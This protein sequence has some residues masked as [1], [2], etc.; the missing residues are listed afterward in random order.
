[1]DN[2][3]E[4]SSDSSGTWERISD[5][6]QSSDNME[7]N[8]WWQKQDDIVISGVSGRFPR[9]E[10]V[11]EFGDRLLAGEDL[12]TEDDLRWPPGF[13]DLP[14]RHGKLRELKKFDAGFFQVTPKQA[15]FMDPQVR[16]LLEAS[17]EAMVDAGINPID[18]R[19]SKTGVFVGC[20]ASE[21]SGALT[22]D[23][24]SVTG[25]TLTGCVRSMF[26]NRISYTFDLQGPSFSVDTACSSS[27]L[28]LQLAI[29]S[30]R[31]GQCDAAI[32]AGAHLT[33]TPTAALQFLRLGM[34]TDKGSCRSF[35]D[36]GDGYC[37]T[38]GVAAI[39]IQRKKK[40]QRIY[41][42]VLHAK[43]NTDGYKEQGITFPSGERQAQLLQE[44]Y[45][46]AGVD[47]N[48]VYYVESHGTGTKVGD[49]QEANAICQV[50][51]SNRQEP[52]LI[53]SVKSNMGHAEPASGVCSLTKILLSIE[54]Q[55]IPPNLHYN[56]PNQYI[57]GLVDGRLKVVTEPTPLPG[58]IIGVNS[59]GF[60]GSNTHVILKAADHVAK[61]ITNH[62]LTR[63]VTYCGRTQE[64]VE[65]MFTEIETHKDDYYLQS[66]LSNQSNMPANLLPFRGYMLLDREN[67]E[68]PLKNITKVPITEPR[69]IYF[70][71]S[72]MGSQWP[73]MAI[74]LMKIPFFDES[75]RAS[76]KTLEEFGLDVYGM[77]CNPDPE[78]YTNNTMNCMLAITAIQIALTDTLTALGVSPDGIIGHSTGE[79]GCGYADGG[80][81]REQ[82]MRLA[83]HRGTTIMKHTE[84]KGAMAAV[85]L[86]W[87]EVKAQ[88][89][90]GVVAACHNGADNV[91]ISGDADGVDAFCNQLKERDIFAKKVD[92][93]GIPF[94]SPAM[95]AVK[96]EM[97]ES[98]RT[99]VP[100]PN[101]DHPNGF[102]HRFQRRLG[103]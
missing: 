71:Y 21:T 59:F 66:L 44:V 63:V 67:N 23:P 16:I 87:E 100:E 19:G 10:N 81:T 57:P 76:S 89:P 58:G 73:G 28:A 48:S 84:I 35:D 101:Q 33:L 18:L 25:Y 90:P 60:G 46:E 5:N 95:L 38:E 55:M 82:T 61:P 1:M 2:T 86:N 42:T 65:K 62:G 72:G 14:K 77:L 103:I 70:V 49:P 37:R 94:H 97:I 3:G 15:N 12:V 47:P 8:N 17:W 50:F 102:R 51:C 83:Y 64:A 7:S 26:S 32:V 13:Y 24:E 98:M 27:L 40:A 9:C 68:T 45:S 30:I 79:M 29:D 22:Q 41:A 56:T 11:K 39:F 52:L 85:G 92:T 88:A 6:S 96:D 69:P 93:S 80:I 20:S 74:K 91:T 53:G 31:Q 36:S 34:L 75:L 54:R 43:S 99:A 78:Q 4:G